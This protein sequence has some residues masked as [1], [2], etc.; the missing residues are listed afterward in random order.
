MRARV[1]IGARGLALIVAGLLVAAGGVLAGAKAL[2]VLGAVVV[3]GILADL[4]VLQTQGLRRPPRLSRVVAPNPSFVGQT[5]TVRLRPVVTRGPLPPWGELPLTI[6]DEVMA[7]MDPTSLG[8]GADYR[9]RPPERGEW[10]LGPAR[11]RVTSPL[12]AW[13]RTVVDSATATLMAWPAVAPLDGTGILAENI[14]EQRTGRSG[15]RVPL[16]DD[17]TLRDYRPGDDLRRIHW[18]SS[19]RLGKLMTRTEEPVESHHAWLGLWFAPGS[20]GDA[21]ELAISLAASC[22][23]AWQA[24]GYQVDLWC[25]PWRLGGGLAAQLNGLALLSVE[26]AAS[27]R[28][29]VP[30][31]Q[32]TTDGPAVFL[33]VPGPV[34]PA[35]GR[36]RHPDAQVEAGSPW[37]DLPAATPP[38]QRRS[39]RRQPRVGVLVGDDTTGLVRL[40][41]AGWTPAHCPGT[42]RLAEAASRCSAALGG[43]RG[44]GADALFGPPPPPQ[45]QDAGGPDTWDDVF[46]DVGTPAGV[47][48]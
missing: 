7:E 18:S 48:R 11:L 24:S 16:P 1:Q 10:P 31:P 32:G 47:A 22:V 36:S 21:R 37:D 13:T 17:M 43:R 27:D 25:G 45:N 44:G 23:L 39:K 2:V 5:V 33:A 30:A 19:A 46:G 28:P 14:E 41:E 8:H 12:Q 40:R 29:H 35:T 9:I 6:D 42:L 3:M 26:E 15:A 20:A 38:S 34:A 4:V